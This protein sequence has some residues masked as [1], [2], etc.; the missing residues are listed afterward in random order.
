MAKRGRRHLHNVPGVLVVMARQDADFGARVLNPETREEALREA[1]LVEEDY[2]DDFL[3]DLNSELD[4]IARMSFQDAMQTLR[5][6]G[7]AQ[8]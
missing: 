7:V 8:M 6:E 5:D 4:E 2:D 1:G 3:H